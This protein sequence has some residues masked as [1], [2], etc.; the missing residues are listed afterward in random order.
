MFDLYRSVAVIVELELIRIK[1][2]A[3][4][5]VLRGYY[6]AISKTL[7]KQQME[8]CVDSLRYSILSKS[9]LK[10]VSREAKK[11]QQ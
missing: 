4:K 1:P 3:Y 6:N 7:A 5:R 9:R 11:K 10:I 2:T 8:H